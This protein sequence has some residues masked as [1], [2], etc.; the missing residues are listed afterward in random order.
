MGAHSTMQI[1]IEDA[2]ILLVSKVL[3][4]SNDMLITVLDDIY[5]DKLYRFRIV[6]EYDKDSSLEKYPDHTYVFR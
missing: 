3:A 5:H 1:T 6:H 2:R 4:M